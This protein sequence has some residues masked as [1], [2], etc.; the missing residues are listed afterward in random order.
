LSGTA[1]LKAKELYSR[2]KPNVHSPNFVGRIAFEIDS[3]LRSSTEDNV[4]SLSRFHSKT[5]E[6]R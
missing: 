1:G 3:M 6:A 4:P 2:L 5:M